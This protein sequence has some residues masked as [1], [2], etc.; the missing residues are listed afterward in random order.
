M[1]AISIFL[2]VFVSLAIV[3]CTDTPSITTNEKK[4]FESSISEKAK[5]IGQELLNS[6][7]MICHKLALSHDS[8]LAPPMRGVQMNYKSE[9]STK[10]EFV[11]AVVNWASNPDS[12]KSVMKGAIDQFGVMPNLF[13]PREELVEIANYMYEADFPKPVWAGKGNGHGKAT[14]E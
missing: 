11:E 8:L 7:C 3:N 6:K 1:R 9:F 10:E 2:G 14:R 12:T 4:G 5:P 13:Y